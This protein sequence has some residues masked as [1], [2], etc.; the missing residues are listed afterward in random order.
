MTLWLDGEVTVTAFFKAACFDAVTKGVSC[1]TAK[2]ETLEAL[3]ATGPSLLYGGELGKKVIERLTELGGCLTM[4]D[5]LDTEPHWIDPVAATYRGRT[6]HVPPPPCEAFQ[7]LLTLRILEGFE[8]A[9]LPH[10][11]TEHLD[12][13]LR[14]RH[15]KGE[16]RGSVRYC[17][18]REI[19]YFLGVQFLP[20]C[21]W[22]PEAYQPEHL[23]DLR[24][25]V[26][27]SAK[28]AVQ[29]ADQAGC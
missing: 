3:A 27:E 28:R 19:G 23:L 14:I 2:L 1:E 20:G 10:N 26:Q 21:E 12:T 13:V 5:L 4:D 25:L 29:K 6:I 18:Y 8:L 22:S 24:E 7:Y 16:F 17:L 15:P 11:G 9:K